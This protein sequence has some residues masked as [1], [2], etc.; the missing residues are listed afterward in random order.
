MYQ[1]IDDPQDEL[2]ALEGGDK[3]MVIWLLAIICVALIGAL[4]FW[5]KSDTD[6]NVDD[7]SLLR[8]EQLTYRNASSEITAPMRRARLQ[9]FLTTYPESGYNHAVEAQLDVINLH[10]AKRWRELNDIT[11][12][13]SI[14]REE[15]IKALDNFEIKW[16]GALLGGRDEDI[17]ALREDLMQMEETVKTQSRK[18]KDLKSPIPD[19]IPDTIL[20]GGPRPLPSP[21]ITR[22]APPPPKVVAPVQRDIVPPKVRRSVQPRYPN[23]A[24]RRK[25]SA[26]VVLKLNID[27]KGKVAMTEVV[28]VTAERYQKDFIRA[29][30][31][32]AMRTRFHPQTVDGRP[33]AA[34]GI[35]RR[36]RFDP[37]L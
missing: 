25:V 26:L 2:D 27:E 37:N 21:V 32:A 10:E 28:D 35:V 23:K 34:M 29:A 8:A 36:Y 22:P 30:E 12:A 20:A 9:D 5:T 15:K 7:G 33:Q 11:F 6:I 17:K 18:L 31:R 14:D 3:R 16:G 24:M 19:T 13:P 4:I 1:S